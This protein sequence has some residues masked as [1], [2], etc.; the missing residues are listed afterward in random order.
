[1]LIKLIIKLKPF[2]PIPTVAK[3]GQRSE[4]LLK[5]LRAALGGVLL[6]KLLVIAQVLR[7]AQVKSQ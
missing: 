6:A 2:Y 3:W 5:V 1:M 4:L 7:G